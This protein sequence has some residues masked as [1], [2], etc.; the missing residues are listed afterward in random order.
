MQIFKFVTIDENNIYCWCTT[1]ILRTYR[2]FMQYTLD[3]CSKPEIYLLWD[4]N[5][6]KV[7]NAYKIVTEVY[8]MRKRTFEEKINNIQTGKCKIITS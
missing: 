5:N 8:A 7:Y 6:D 2:D 3:G 4:T 1:N